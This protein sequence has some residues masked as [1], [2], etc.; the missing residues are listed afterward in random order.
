MTSANDFLNQYNPSANAFLSQYQPPPD[1][2]DVPKSILGG[3]E[4]MAAAVPMVLPNIL[5]QMVAGPQL[6]GIGLKDTI[7]GNPTTQNPKLWQPFY[8]S[9]DM[10][11]QL[12]QSIQP[13]DP[14]TPLGQVGNITG[15]ALGAVL[16]GKALSALGGVAGTDDPI[17]TSADVR[18]KASQAY[19]AADNIGGMA[20]PN[21]TNNFLN[22]ASSN[23]LPTSARVAALPTVANSPSAS[24]LNDLQSWRN[25]PMSLGETQDLDQHIGDLIDSNVHPTTGKLTAEGNNLSNIQQA[26]RQSWENIT[27]NDTVGGSQGFEAAKNARDLWAAAAKSNDIERII[28]RAADMDNPTTALKTGFRNLANNPSRLR[29]FTPQ[30]IEDINNAKQT[31]VVGRSLQL[32]SSG[33]VPILATITGGAEAGGLGVALSTTANKLGSGM[34]MNKANQVLS[35]IMQ[36]PAVQNAFNPMNTQPPLPKYDFQ[37]ALAAAMGETGAQINGS[38]K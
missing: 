19:K 17:L 26:L 8:G 32:A 7:E 14:T 28:N 36:R 15:Q 35:S 10:L 29:G 9:E 11:K 16:S 20:K 33:L 5:N 21:I 4:H 18:A 25:T 12:P 30:E 6:L 38:G 2:Y 23:A 13:H 27:P 22:A 1:P 37:R 34:Q 24:L 31:G 3:A